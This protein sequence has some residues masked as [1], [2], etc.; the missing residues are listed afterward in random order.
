VRR[1]RAIGTTLVAGA[2]AGVGVIAAAGFERP[3]EPS[4][5]APLRALA[6]PVRPALRIGAPEPLDDGPDASRWGYLLHTVDARAAPSPAARV[7]AAVA[8]RT[9]EGTPTALPITARRV[10]GGGR[11][12]LR[13][14]LPVL[15]SGTSGWIPRRALGSFEINR[16]RLVIDLAR[17]R[18]TLLRRGRALMHAPIGVGEARWPTPRGR[19]LVR[20]RLERYASPEYGPIAFGTSARSAVQTDWPAGGF[21]GIHGTDHP[22]LIPG[23]VSHGCVRLRNA[24]ILRLARLMPVGTPIEIQ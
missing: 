15:P 13:A 18:L 24:D 8:R 23:R 4:R 20:N 17:L 2:L 10:V 5:A 1:R 22:E 19:F 14:T 12:W 11:I 21:V 16:H 6:P 9:P 7:V 3:A